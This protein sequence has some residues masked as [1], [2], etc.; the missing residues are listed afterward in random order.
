MRLSS[1]V[2]DVSLLVNFSARK[3]F[4]NSPEKR[5][6]LQEKI[7]EAKQHSVHDL[8]EE[9]YFVD[10]MGGET[11]R[12]QSPARSEATSWECDNCARNETS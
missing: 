4:Q 9:L 7:E 11:L 12:G 8:Q 6:S 2:A 5:K 3:E 10:A 1:L